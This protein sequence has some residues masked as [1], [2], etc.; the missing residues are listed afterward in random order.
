MQPIHNFSLQQH[1]G[2]YETWPRRTALLFQGDATGTEIPG[3]VIEAQYR[4]DA[5]YLIITSQDCPF[6]ESNEF[7][8]LDAD[9]R[10]IARKQLLAP[11]AGYL[12]QAHWPLTHNSLRLHYDERLFYTLSIERTRGILGARHSLALTEF[13]DI[14]MDTRPR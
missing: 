6:E 14:E 1:Q 4:C 2:P 12:L 10:I 5:G 13:S 9:F 11:Y 3:Y 8:L 7:V